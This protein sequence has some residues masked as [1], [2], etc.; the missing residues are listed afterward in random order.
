VLGEM[1]NSVQVGGHTDSR[2]YAPNSTKTNWE[3]SFER[4]DA[5]RRVL[6]GN[7]LRS[8]QVSRVLAYADSQPLKP[9][10]PMADENRRLSI[11]AERMRPTGV[12]ASDEAA[13]DQP[14]R[15][16][17]VVLPPDAIP[18]RTATLE[19]HLTDPTESRSETH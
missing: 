17:P 4:A 19:K 5:A 11:L 8:K 16:S 2:P 14:L 10:D 3:L 15:P 9:E 12:D 1:P 13:A 6:E 7:G 18:E